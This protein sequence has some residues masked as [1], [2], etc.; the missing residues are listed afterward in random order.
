MSSRVTKRHFAN[1]GETP[2]AVA[3]LLSLDDR[4]DRT[5]MGVPRPVVSV[6]ILTAF[7]LL[8]GAEAARAGLSPIDARF[9]VL[10]GATRT[11]EKLVEYQWLNEDRLNVGGQF[12]IG[13]GPVSVGAR[14]WTT[15]GEQL[16]TV[17]GLAT[18]SLETRLVAG[19]AV[20][21]VDMLTLG[22]ASLFAQGSGGRMRLSYGTEL[23]RFTP[24][25]SS[26][27][28][29]VALPPIDGWIGGGGVG[30]DYAT[31]LGVSVGAV[32]DRSW[33]QMETAHRSGEE[34]VRTTESFGEWTV[35]AEL[36][37]GF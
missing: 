16:L 29:E 31:P 9:S 33:F 7:A 6:L 30:L 26:E 2:S 14:G 17:P 28:L 8:F 5:S 27:E 20:L 1:K 18:Q 21:R 37:W 34:I 4:M 24:T 36:G 25:G 11:G 13:R 23:L 3:G 32:V 12:L 15:T 19:E 35:R 22:G 10:A